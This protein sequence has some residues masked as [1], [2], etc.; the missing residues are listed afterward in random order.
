MS[1][2]TCHSHRCSSRL[3]WKKFLF[4]FKIRGQN[5]YC[6]NYFE[7][8]KMVLFC[9]YL[10]CRDCDFFLN[11]Q[12]QYVSMSFVT[13][14]VTKNKRF[15]LFHSSKVVDVVQ[16]KQVIHTVQKSLF[17]I[18]SDTEICVY[19]CFFFQKP[20]KILHFE[21]PVKIFRVFYF[22]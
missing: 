18:I 12:V 13:R 17:D 10:F 15:L 16:E 11:T 14:N 5:S 9:T 6:S 21:K 3:K 7:F 19:A 8:F 20:I 4:S 2:K 22:P 1:V